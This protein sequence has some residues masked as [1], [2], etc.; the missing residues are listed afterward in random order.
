MRY[1]VAMSSQT[2]AFDFNDSTE[3][4]EPFT[5]WDGVITDRGSRYAVTLGRVT[6]RE[7]IQTFLKQ[8]RAPK[9]FAEATHHSWAARIAHEGAIYETKRDD[10]ETGAG[11]VILRQLQKRNTANCIVCVTRWYGGVKLMG[12]RFAHIQSATQ[13]ALDSLGE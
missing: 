1:Y 10:G 3:P 9:K 12:D 4:T 13:I 7:D 6:N 5:Q 2:N 8:V 11:M